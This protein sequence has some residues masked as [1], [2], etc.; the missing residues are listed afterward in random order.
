MK[1]YAHG[2][3]YTYAYFTVYQLN[4]MKIEREKA[5]DRCECGK[6]INTKLKIENRRSGGKQRF[7]LNP[8][9]SFV[10]RV[11]YIIILLHA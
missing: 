2:F 7:C 3:P 9:K 11:V 1:S 8:L 6:N 10:I 5:C 4:S